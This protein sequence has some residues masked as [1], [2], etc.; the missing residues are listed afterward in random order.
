MKIHAFLLVILCPILSWAGGLTVPFYLN[1]TQVLPKGVRSLRYAGVVTTVDGWYNSTG[2]SSGIAQPFNQQLSYSR[3]LK[4][5]SNENLKLNVESQLKN[6]GVDLNAIAGSSTADINTQVQVSLPMMAYGITNRWMVAVTIPIFQVNQDIKTGF[7][8]S[9]QLQQLV[10]SFSEKSRKQTQLIQSKLR[11][12]IATELA[13]KGYKPLRSQQQTF[14][15]DLTLYSKYLAAKG[16]N[17]SWA[18]AQTLTLPTAQVK[19]ITRL[20]DPTP[21]D[22]Q[23]DFGVSSIFQVPVSSKVQ[24]VNQT[25]YTVQ[26]SDIRATRIPFSGQERLA[27]DVDEGAH[28]DLGDIMSTSFSALYSPL[29]WLNFGG[30]YTLAYKQR[31]RWTGINASAS[32]YHAL[33]VQ[34]EQYMQGLYAQAG[35]STINAYRRKAFFLPMMASLGLGRVVAGRNIANNPMWNMQVTMFF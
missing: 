5:E 23:V 10:K 32:R 24:L 8:A 6:K 12:V 7:V 13:N 34:T 19:D 17:Y 25:S 29:D 9:K 2:A 15:G 28:R 20:A 14:I 35:F 31:D 22:G 18:V 16:L 27:R 33:G 1:T 11:D 3:L 4:S 30:S 26:F 21:G